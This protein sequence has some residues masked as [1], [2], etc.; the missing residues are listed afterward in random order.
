[1]FGS[2]RLAGLVLVDSSVGEEPAPK[3]GGNFP[4]R[5]REDRDKALGEFVRAIFAKHPPS[6]PR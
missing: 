4:Q 6:E 5:L 2:E 1:M 3:A